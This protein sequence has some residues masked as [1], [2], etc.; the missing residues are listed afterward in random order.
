MTPTIKL[1]RIGGVQVGVHWS[2]LGILAILVVAL[3]FARWPQLLPGYPWYVYVFAAL[4]GAVLFLG[5]LLAHEVSHAIV[6]RRNDIPVEGI[7][8]WLLGGVARLRGEA[9]TPG[10]ELRIAAAGPLTSVAVAVFFALVTGLLVLADAPDLVSA[11]AGY[12]A[13]VNVVL[14]VFNLVPAAPLDG[15]R[16]LRAALWKWRGDRTR[17]AI[18]SARAGRGFGLFLIFLGAWRLLFAGFGD[19]LWW[20]LIGLFITSMA[21]AEERQAEFGSAVAGVRVRDV[22]TPDPDT[23]DGE[24]TVAD[25][26]RD[27]ALARRHSAFPLLDQAGRLQGLITLN[28]LKQVPPDR[29]ETTPLREVACPPG[30]IAMAEPDEPVSDLLERLGGCADGRA[31]VFSEGNLVG[32]VSPS[33]I[34]RLV[35]L[36]G[37]DTGWSRGGADVTTSPYARP[38]RRV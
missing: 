20:I 5:S 8:L 11:I 21:S 17:A 25:F 16:I 24:S 15:G 33:D 30:E 7:T 27:V 4:V 9:R 12:L 26:L 34:S 31:L 2:V 28:R 6:A 19:G 35:T 29:R 18:W 13:A 10:A 14:A 22:M 3:G 37:L 32:I 23:T 36:R 38:E 1:G